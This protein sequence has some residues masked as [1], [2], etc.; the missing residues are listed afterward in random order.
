V[1]VNE[2]DTVRLPDGPVTPTKLLTPLS[3][4]TEVAPLVAQL[5]VADPPEGILDWDRY[6]AAVGIKPDG[7][8]YGIRAVTV[9]TCELKVLP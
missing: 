9:S 5:S 4:D 8:M 1:V 3:I 6:R 7:G 2:G